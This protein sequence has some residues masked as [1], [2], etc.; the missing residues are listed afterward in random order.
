MARHQNAY[1]AVIS[2]TPIT[3]YEKECSLA[4]WASMV[5]LQNKTLIND[6]SGVWV[7]N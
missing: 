4:S 1:K 5:S 3:K 6:V 2:N 7:L